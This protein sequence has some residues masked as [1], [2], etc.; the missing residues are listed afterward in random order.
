MTE[1]LINDGQPPKKTRRPGAGRPRKNDI[2]KPTQEEVLGSNPDAF[3][4]PLFAK[5]GKP[6]STL[7]VTVVPAGP[8]KSQQ[9]RWNA[10]FQ[11]QYVNIERVRLG[12]T[13]IKDGE[14]RDRM[15]MS[16]L[17]IERE[18]HSEDYKKFRLAKSASMVQQTISDI[19]PGIRSTLVMFMGQ[20][21]SIK[22]CTICGGTAALD[23]KKIHEYMQFIIMAMS[24][25]GLDKIDT[26]FAENHDEMDT[27]EKIAEAVKIIEEAKKWPN[28]APQRVVQAL[29]NQTASTNRAADRGNAS[30][31]S[32]TGSLP[33][34]ANARP[35]ETIHSIRASEAVIPVQEK[36][37]G[38]DIVKPIRED[39]LVDGGLDTIRSGPTSDS[40]DSEERRNLDFSREE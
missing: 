24:K 40:Q 18:L 8:Y 13:P 5:G 36:I 25:F 33:G 26:S 15:K 23:M 30:I 21:Q 19:A 29:V 7:H 37:S 11:F 22:K 34:D 12:L 3:Q 38:D 9:E 27:E 10:I 31:T 2:F 14:I 35:D 16:P 17:D 32:D 39:R 6:K 1:N 28:L 4:A 20:L